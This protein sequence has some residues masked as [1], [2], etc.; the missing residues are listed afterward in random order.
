MSA[1]RAR[2]LMLLENCPYP[3]DTRVRNEALALTRAGYQVTVISPKGRNHRSY[4]V[5]D[6]VC[7][8]RYAPFPSRGGAL[9]FLLEYAHAMVATFV[10]SLR[11]WARPGFDIIHAHNP[12]DTFVLIGA[13]YKILGKRFVFD[14]H[15]LSPEMY[16]AR[17][18][19]G[20]R[21]AFHAL[22]AF[23]RLTF[24]LADHVVSTNGSYRRIA[25][26]RGGVPEAR[27]TVVRNGPDLDVIKRR[28]PPQELRESAGHLLGYIGEMGPQDGIDYLL[29]SLKHLIEDLGKTRLQCILIGDGEALPALKETV[30]S[31]QLHDH[32]RF[33]GRLPQTELC[34]WITAVDICVDPDPSNPYNDRSTMVKL[35]EYMALSKPIVAFDLPEHR[36][37]AGDAAL[38]AEPNDELDFA[39]KIALLMDDPSLRRR[40]GREGRRRVED[41][42][43]WSYQ[44]ACLVKA[45]ER[46][47]GGT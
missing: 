33:L 4:E 25:T 10:L 24:R 3:N 20:G 26:E 23:E 46:L 14:H 27:V 35:M 21:L 47:E 37:S 8:L 40:L 2:V 39:R 44:A 36:V 12:P 11:A 22:R 16:V 42:L 9:G 29:R 7:V 41:S 34:S 19:N 6:G 15:D 43:A 18:P 5:I 38:Y 13:L 1:R 30:R 45:Y 28:P 17:F 31:L 32:V